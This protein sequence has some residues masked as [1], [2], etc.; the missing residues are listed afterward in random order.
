MVVVAEGAESESAEDAVDGIGL[1]KKYS[2]IWD[3][4][5]AFMKA[6]SRST[7]PPDLDSLTTEMRSSEA[8]AEA[9]DVGLLS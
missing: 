9:L 6:A 3:S 1:P 2:R 5:R 8:A 4:R 7:H